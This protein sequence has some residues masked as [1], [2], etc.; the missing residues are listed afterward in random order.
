MKDS[1]AEKL[2]TV[3]HG[4]P[5]GA[6]M[7]A[8]LPFLFLFAYEDVQT[9]REKR[10][11]FPSSPCHS[12]SIII[13]TLNEENHIV[14]CL[15][16]F[17]DNAR[18][19]ETL[20]IDAGSEDRTCILARESGA[21][22]IIHD[23]PI[24]DGGGRGGQIKS[25]IDAAK[26]DVVMILHADAMLPAEEID[27]VLAALNKHP[28]VIGGAVGCRFDSS[29]LWFRFIELANDFRAAFFK[30][31]F[32]DQVQFFR[33]QPVVDRDMFPGIALME[34]VEFSI[35]LHRLGRQIYLIGNVLVST[36]RWDKTGFRNAPWV[37]RQVTTYLIRRLWSDPD[38]V[39]LYRKYYNRA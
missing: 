32:G 24:E 4:L 36:R 9:W 22:V 8:R 3:A 35:R 12:V 25:G 39:K 15:Q 13:P 11:K 1:L 29:R 21:R 34:D 14:R 19:V 10:K 2:K 28:G 27:R 16:A 37:L 6:Q 20:V 31:S 17:S 38:T 7:A 30:I 33:R 5:V 18:V 23:Q 26:G